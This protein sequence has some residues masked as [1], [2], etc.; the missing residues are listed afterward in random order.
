MPNSGMPFARAGR[1]ACRDFFKHFG[2][3]SLHGLLKETVRRWS[4][5]KKHLNNIY[6]RTDAKAFGSWVES[7]KVL[8]NFTPTFV[9]LIEYYSQNGS[10]M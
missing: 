4:L 8:D 3:I 6:S 5:S 9:F 10:S 7:L 2:E 1:A